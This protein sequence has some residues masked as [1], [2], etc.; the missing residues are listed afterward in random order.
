VFGRGVV[1][2]DGSIIIEVGTYSE[3]MVSEPVATMLVGAAGIEVGT[4]TWVETDTAGDDTTTDG[5]G[6]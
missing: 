4:G 1:A 6:D 5:T 2:E 3:A